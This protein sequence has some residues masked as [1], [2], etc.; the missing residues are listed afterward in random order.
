MVKAGS[1]TDLIIEIV[2][3][4]RQPLDFRI[5]A[6]ESLHVCVRLRVRRRAARV[7]GGGGRGTRQ[8]R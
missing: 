5:L 1:E 3:L 8:V 7:V 2:H 4:P 6:L